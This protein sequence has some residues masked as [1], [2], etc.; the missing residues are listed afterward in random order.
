MTAREVALRVLIKVDRG[1]GFVDN[2]LTAVASRHNLTRRDRRFVQELTYGVTRLRKRLDYVIDRYCVRR[3]ADC[4]LRN[5]LRMGTY[6]I[7]SMDVPDYA[8]VD[9][10]VRLLGGQDQRLAAFVNAVLRRIAAE[11]RTLNFP[12]PGK[13]PVQFLA[14]YY[15]HPEWL[16]SR[17]IRHFGYDETERLCQLDNE[18]PSLALRVNRR[19]ASAEEV[20]RLL[21]Q[22]GIASTPGQY[23]EY[24]LRVD[25][26]MPLTEVRAFTDGLI[27]IQDESAALVGEL[28]NPQPGEIV[29]DLCAS[30]GGKTTHIAELMGD[31]G[32][33]VAVDVSVTRL[34][35]LLENLERLRLDS[36]IPVV[37]DSR[38][39]RTRRADLVLLDVPCSGTGTLRRR[40]DLRWRR[41]ESDLSVLR[42]LQMALLANAANILKSGGRLVY[43]TCSIE[44]EENEEVVA[45][46]LGSH[47]EFSLE[48]IPRW[49]PR[50]LV[51]EGFYLAT[52]PHLHGI[53]GMFASV[54]VKGGRAHG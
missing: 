16:V 47:P 32:L 12:D 30:P 27:Q 21:R 38:Y 25:G 33:V 44:P 6:Q 18:V 5:V 34:K 10:S 46:F 40:P 15:S 28:V 26:S 9:E 20:A 23:L 14:T 48:S 29:L 51:R 4:R 45:E 17:W 35:P 13:D 1:E 2:V 22:E 54:L 19:R 49:V 43:S 36:V 52:L 7:L 11:G 41:L 31:S 39:F 50:E 8:A 3:S 42:A 53:D 37:S 24:V